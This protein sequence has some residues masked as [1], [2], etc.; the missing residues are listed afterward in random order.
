LHAAKHKLDCARISKALYIYKDD[1]TRAAF[2]MD[3]PQVAL[4]SFSFATLLSFINTEK[5]KKKKRK[6]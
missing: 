6:E 2:D 1:L 5:K 4:L 3:T